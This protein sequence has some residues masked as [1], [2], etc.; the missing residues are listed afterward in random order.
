MIRLQDQYSGRFFTYL[1][2]ESGYLKVG[3][4]GANQLEFVDFGALMTWLEETVYQHF[5]GVR[6]LP[7]HN[8]LYSLSCTNP[9]FGYSPHE[10]FIIDYEINPHEY[11]LWLGNGCKLS[12][13]MFQHNSDVRYHFERFYHDFM[14]KEKHASEFG[15]AGQLQ[16]YLVIF[17]R[18]THEPIYNYV[19]GLDNK[20]IIRL[21]N[22]HGNVWSAVVTDEK[23]AAFLA[24]SA[25]QYFEKTIKLHE[26]STPDQVNDW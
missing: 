1:D 16:Y 22:Y 21:D 6:Y 18:P 14:Y 19:N 2:Y 12:Y 3:D 7:F 8:F 17:A 9:V 13:D 11:A 25:G 15:S 5:H 26:L 10:C 20:N 23:E 24:L 4:T